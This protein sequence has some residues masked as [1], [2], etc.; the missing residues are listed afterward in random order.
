MFR[1]AYPKVNIYCRHWWRYRF[2]W[3]K[4]GLEMRICKKCH[5]KALT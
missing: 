1:R 4:N 5:N 2:W 3:I